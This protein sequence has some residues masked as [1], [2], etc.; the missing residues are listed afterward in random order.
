MQ[1]KF[2]AHFAK[3]NVLF[4]HRFWWV[5]VFEFEN[6][7]FFWFLIPL[8]WIPQKLKNSKNSHLFP[9][10]TLIF[11]MKK[12]LF[13]RKI[14][15]NWFYSLGSVWPSPF[16]RQTARMFGGKLILSECLFFLDFASNTI[17]P[18]YISSFLPSASKR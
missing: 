11:D 12:G 2:P 6:R 3:N 18:S 14:S 5:L 10:K 1:H 15:L 7:V 4:F 13:R 17:F 9:Y 16:D 8:L